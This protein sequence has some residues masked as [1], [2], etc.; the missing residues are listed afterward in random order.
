[1][2]TAVLNRALPTATCA[3]MG[4]LGQICQWKKD[5][6]IAKRMLPLASTP[7]TLVSMKKGSEDL[8]SRLQE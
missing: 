6:R 8:S 4:Q 5:L 3:R 7:R 2:G 1:M